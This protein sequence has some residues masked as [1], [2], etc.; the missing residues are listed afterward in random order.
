MP[1]LEE[2]DRLQG[3]HGVLLHKYV[4]KSHES[5]EKEF[6]RWVLARPHTKN[7]E[8]LLELTILKAPFLKKEIPYF[9]IS[10]SDEDFKKL[11][12]TPWQ[13]LCKIK[14]TVAWFSFTEQNHFYIDFAHP[15][16]FGGGFRGWGNVQEETL[17]YE[18]PTLAQLAFLTQD[19]PIRAC[20]G[21]P[22]T[23]EPTP[24]IIPT[25]KRHA[26]VR[27]LYGNAL[28]KVSNKDVTAQ[29]EHLDIE[30]QPEIHILGMSAQ[31]WNGE[32]G[33]YDKQSLSY[34]FKAAYLAFEGAKTLNS[35]AK[36]HTGP[37]GCGVFQ[38]SEKTMTVIQLLAA[39]FAGVSPIFEGLNHP[40]NPSYTQECIEEAFTLLLAH[41]HPEAVFDEILRRQ[42]KDE[43]WA[44]KKSA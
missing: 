11:L 8:K 17:F 27:E 22:P 39:S 34:H 2:M 44:P 29:I 28:E 20:E 31:R 26:I 42:N 30:D 41:R 25:I 3:K 19:Q 23:G 18:F 43:S 7:K 35:H 33:A 40:S 10:Q 6:H 38:N 5:L 14:T 37:W 15:S 24:F 12:T 16:Q 1:L 21:L 4:A 13:T 9:Q 32:G 36:V